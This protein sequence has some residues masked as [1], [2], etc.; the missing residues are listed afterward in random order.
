MKNIIKADSFSPLFA[1][2]N[3]QLQ[4]LPGTIIAGHALPTSVKLPS[5]LK[6]GTD[7]GIVV[8]DGEVICHELNH[9]PVA[10]HIG[11]FH[12]GLDGNIVGASIWDAL[13]RPKAKDPRGMVLSGDCWVDIYF[14]NVDPHK[15]GTSA[16]GVE[17]ASAVNWW[18]AVATLSSHGKQ[19]L[20]NAEFSVAMHGVELEKTAGEK[21]T[22]T[23][24]IE[25][26]R[27]AC[28]I[29]QATGCLWT[30]CRD[31]DPS[32]YASVMGGYWVSGSAGPRRLYGDDPDYG[33]YVIGARGRCDHL[34][35]DQSEAKA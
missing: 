22:S 11:G 1:T 26:L 33:W 27:S 16:A 29:E 21:P 9:A 7:Y 6:P 3:N 18:D 13:F 35:P 31:F 4:V 8:E 20:S 32:G 14:L 15:Y 2:N 19:L 23:G 34:C 17:I 5:D 28:G 30:W 12:V 25:G 10:T 24:H